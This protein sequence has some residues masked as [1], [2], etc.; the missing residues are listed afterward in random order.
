MYLEATDS[1]RK[2]MCDCDQPANIKVTFTCCRVCKAATD[3]RKSSEAISMEK[4]VA[5][6]G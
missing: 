5:Q 1:S 2:Y 4:I 3:G 6:L